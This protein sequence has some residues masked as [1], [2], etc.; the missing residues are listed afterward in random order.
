[1]VVNALEIS[2]EKMRKAFNFKDMCNLMKKTL[3]VIIE[4]NEE[5]WYVGS[6]PELPGCHTQ[7]KT[8]DKLMER[9]KE[10]IKLYL[11]VEL[12]IL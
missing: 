9:I 3:P 12:D 1:M 8:I 11:E 5:G 6:I 2:T 4:R 7:A 10:A